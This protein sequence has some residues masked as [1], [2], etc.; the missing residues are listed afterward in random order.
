MVGQKHTFRDY[1][2]F[3]LERVSRIAREAADGVYTEKCGL[4]IL[5]IRVLRIVA[6]QPRQPVSSVVRDSMLD[7]TLVSRIIGRLVGL[8]LIERSISSK[9]ARQILLVATAAGRQRVR[10]A[11]ALGD[12]LNLDLL[13]MLDDHE[14]KVF[15][16][17][18]AKLA[19]WRPNNRLRVPK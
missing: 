3:R 14:I 16:Q 6:E 18:L 15:E 17:C 7:R 5:H 1:V 2:N 11:N 8:K 13:H 10:K 4:D 9:D 19:K 12:A